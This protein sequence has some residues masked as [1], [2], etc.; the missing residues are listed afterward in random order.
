MNGHDIHFF[1]KNNKLFGGVLTADQYP[2]HPPKKLFIINNQNSNQPGMHWT[3][4]DFTGQTNFFFDSIGHS[5]SFYNWKPM[6]YSKKRYQGDLGTCG[7]FCIYYCHFRAKKLSPKQIL[8][9]FS[10]NRNANDH[11]LIKWMSKYSNSSKN[12]KN[13]K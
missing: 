1:L 7:I 6:P 3:T 12:I 13:M 5:P 10:A 11:K 2:Q 9:H 8:S 4:L